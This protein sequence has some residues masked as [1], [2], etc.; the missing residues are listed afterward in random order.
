MEQGG[1][2]GGAR[3]REG[4]VIVDRGFIQAMYTKSRTSH[5]L[6]RPYLHPP[7]LQSGLSYAELGAGSMSGVKKN[8]KGSK[9]YQHIA[10]QKITKNCEMFL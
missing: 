6:R 10:V 8:Q 5:F 4:G 7:V 3:G 1:K 2:W 9:Q